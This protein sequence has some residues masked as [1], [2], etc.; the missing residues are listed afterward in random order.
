MKTSKRF[1]LPSVICLSDNIPLLTAIAN[2]ISYDDTFA[3]AA[4]LHHIRSRDM[5]I[6]ISSSG[7][8]KNVVN[9]AKLAVDRGAT[10]FT[11]TGFAGGILR[12]IGSKH[13]VSLHIDVN[14]YGIVEDIHN[15]VIHRLV[16]ELQK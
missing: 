3:E 12:E 5:A 14:D 4:N 11:M 15:H 1:D 6:V 7:N 13:G 2:D 16:K 10:L 9:F 8:S